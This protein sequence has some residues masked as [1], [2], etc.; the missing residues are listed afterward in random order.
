MVRLR[1][2]RPPDEDSLEWR[3]T[4]PARLA[5]V[6]ATIDFAQD[7]VLC[8]D[9]TRRDPVVPAVARPRRC[10]LATKYSAPLEDVKLKR[11]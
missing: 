3:I 10:D 8:S 6:S 1:K 9:L 4:R 11:P 5:G 2:G 7:L